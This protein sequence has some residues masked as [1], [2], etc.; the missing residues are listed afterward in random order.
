MPVVY[1]C[2][3]CGFVL[4]H[5]PRV[6][7]DY[8]G[9]KTPGEII[10][11]YGGRCPNCGREL[12]LPRPNDIIVRADRELVETAREIESH[13]MMYKFLKLYE[14]GKRAVVET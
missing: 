14:S 9:I 10:W 12:E 3:A 8:H 7:A 2:K 6:G 5:F 11:L 13:L 1:R 4:Y